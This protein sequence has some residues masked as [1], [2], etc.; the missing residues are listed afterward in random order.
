MHEFALSGHL[1]M[2]SFKIAYFI[3]FIKSFIQSVTKVWSPSPLLAWQ[4]F[5]TALMFVT[6]TFCLHKNKIILGK[7]I[8]LLRCPCFWA[9]SAEVFFDPGHQN[10]TVKGRHNG[11][12]KNYNQNQNQ[13]IKVKNKQDGRR[14]VSRLL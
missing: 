14:P 6:I 2:T 4:H 9:V 5:W 11:K 12:W 1:F 10:S 13:K 7:C 8:P 3:Y